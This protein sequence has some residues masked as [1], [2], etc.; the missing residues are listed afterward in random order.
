MY[1]L[2]SMATMAACIFMFGIFFCLVQNINYIVKIA[3]SGVA[4]TTFFDDGMSEAEIL[5]IGEKIE[6]RSEVSKMVYVSAEK[7]WEEYKE[8]YFSENPQLA[9]GFAD[10]NPLANSAHFEIYVSDVALQDELVEYIESIDGVRKINQSED[11]AN[12]LSNFNALI[13]YAS[14]AV[15]GLLLGVSIFLISNTITIGIHSRKEEIG[16]MKLIGATNTFV[17]T[18]FLIEGILIGIIGGAIPLGL[19]FFGYSKLIEFIS[20]KFGLLTDVLQFL[21][22]FDVFQTLLPVAMILS[23]GIGFFGSFFTTRKHLHV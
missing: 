20:G 5:E 8:I 10:D 11:I 21:P 1:S 4:I 23:V 15:V 19:L 17:R 16:I 22:V 13:G 3:E 14:I 2:A 18:P 6:G 9:E 7:A 12:I